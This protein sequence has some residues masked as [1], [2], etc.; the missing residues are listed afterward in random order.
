MRRLSF[1]LAA[2]ATC[3]SAQVKYEDIIKGPGQNWLTYAGDYSAQRHSPLKQ[4]TTENVNSLVPK[5]TYHVDGATRLEVTPIVV[6]GLMYVTNSNE[7]HAL[8]VRSGRRVWKFLDEGSQLKNVNRGVAILGER[9]YFITSDC[10]LVALH[11]KTGA[12]IWSKQYA[13][14]GKGYFATL[15][16]LAVKDRVIVGVGG[17]EKGIRGFVAALSASTGEELWRT[18]TVPKKGEPASETWGNFNT[19]WGGGGTWMTGTFDPALN[20]I[21]WTTGNPWPDFYAGERRGDNLYSDSVLALDVETGKMK[22]YFQFT[23]GDYHDWDAQSWPVLIDGD[24]KGQKRKLLLHP[25][26]NGFFYVL[27][28]TTGEY[29]NATPFIER[30]NWATGIDNKGRPIEVPNLV[31]NAKGVRI[32]PSVRGASNWMSPSYNPA[33]G[34]FYIP[35]LEQCDVYTTTA[36]PAEILLGFAGGGGEQ[37]PTE[38][39]KFYLRAIDYKTGK[40]VWEYPMTGPGSGWAGTVSTAGGVVFFGDDDGHLVAVDSRNGKH[41]WHYSTG[42][43]LTASPMTFEQDGKQYVTI[44]AGSEI[45][46]FGLFEPVK[47]VPVLSS[48]R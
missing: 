44:A 28:R 42:Q 3:V 24:W 33:T 36:A 19:E 12:V 6:D 45:Y 22:W 34:L 20:L 11:W 4:I 31:P 5:W 25:N 40:R 8:D 32:C 14:P 15:A 18:W 26:R 2:L 46:T 13:D 17:G 7:V 9:V 48:L 35:T 47:P 39:G 10:H 41:L 23:P 27:D 43:R 30:L 38:P 1:A 16:P 29:L 37:I 21:Y